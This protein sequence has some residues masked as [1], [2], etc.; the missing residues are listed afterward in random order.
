VDSAQLLAVDYASRLLTSRRE[1]FRLCFSGDPGRESATFTLTIGRQ[2]ARA[3]FNCISC[4]RY[5]DVR[6]KGLSS[7][8]VTH[9]ETSHLLQEL[10]HLWGHV[11]RR[12]ARDISNALSKW[13]PIKPVVTESSQLE[14]RGKESQAV[15]R[16]VEQ[17]LARSS[18][19]R[20]ETERFLRSKGPGFSWRKTAYGQW[21]A[22]FEK[23]EAEE[24]LEV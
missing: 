22:R 7:V 20:Q 8:E 1:N 11:G 17:T 13:E 19:E 18:R 10:R 3:P 2:L 24:V 23:G 6:K 15:R 16:E 4:R 9:K 21:R 5:A 14:A 12:D